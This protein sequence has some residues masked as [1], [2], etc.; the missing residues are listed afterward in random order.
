MH[1]T[2][3]VT[4]RATSTQTEL[5]VKEGPDE[6]L[7][8]RLGPVALAHPQAVAKLL[9][10]LALWHQDRLRVVLFAADEEIASSS[11]LVDGLGLGIGNL[12]FGVD[13]VLPD[14][15]RRGVRLRGIRNLREL[16]LDA[17]RQSP[18]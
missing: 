9:E 3:T 4:I 10:A 15:R 14:D 1:E 5:L 2:T 6:I 12:H 11:G 18:W 13:V 8:A 16:R 7:I 17:G